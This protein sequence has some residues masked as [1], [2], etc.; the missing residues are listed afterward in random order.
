MAHCIP[1]AHQTGAVYRVRAEGVGFGSCY[2]FLFSNHS[3][4][5]GFIFD[6]KKPWY[7]GFFNSIIVSNTVITKENINASF[8]VTMPLVKPKP[9]K[10]TKQTAQINSGIRDIL[11]IL[12]K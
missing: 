6:H 4:K 2:V 9:H 3:F 12:Q 1:N 5:F 11:V 8:R 10:Q 7:E